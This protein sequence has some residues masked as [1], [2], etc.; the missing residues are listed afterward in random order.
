MGDKL[1]SAA[2]P[3]SPEVVVPSAGEL[4]AVAVRPL[5]AL[6]LLCAV[7]GEMDVSTAPYLRDRLLELISSAGPDL[8]V[9]LGEVG[10]LGA[11]GLTVLVEARAAAAASGEPPAAG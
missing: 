9:D 6:T 1:R 11:A 3:P 8:V 2:R 4:L 5:S 7:S 10:F